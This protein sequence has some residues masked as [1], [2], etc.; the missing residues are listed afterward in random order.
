M[1][2]SRAGF[3]VTGVDISPQP[4]YP[5]SFIQ[6]DVFSLPAKFLQSFD[7]IHASPPCQTFTIF[8]NNKLG[9]EE[10]YQDLIEETRELLL[11]ASRPYVIENVPRAPLINPTVL[12]GS[13][14]E[15]MHDV[16]RHRLFET[17]WILASPRGCDHSIW[18]E[19]KYVGGRSSSR[20][21]PQTLVRNTI[22]IGRRNI[23]I[24]VQK[25]G[26]GI[27]WPMTIEEISEAVPPAYTKHIGEYFKL[28]S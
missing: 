5:F 24:E 10:N 18:K 7:L 21:G 12:C 8:K 27:D 6:R 17:N 9:F 11:S 16:K 26:M 20:G 15:E 22:E 19:I 14:F 4:H 1:G 25:W 3:S 13:M 28:F 2:Y 23:P